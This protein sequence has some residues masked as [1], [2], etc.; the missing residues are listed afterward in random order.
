M[1]LVCDYPG[2]ISKTEGR[3]RNSRPHSS[4]SGSISFK[5]PMSHVQRWTNHPKDSKVSMQ[6]PQESVEGM[7]T[8]EFPVSKSGRRGGRYGVYVDFKVNEDMTAEDLGRMWEDGT[9]D[10]TAA[11][12]TAIREG[13]EF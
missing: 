6:P 2:S 5:C 8:R 3:G 11:I 9:V 1:M 12:R 13:I 4:V 7:Y 10:G